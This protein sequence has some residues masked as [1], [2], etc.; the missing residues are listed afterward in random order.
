[1]R[2]LALGLIL[3]TLSVSA[4]CYFSESEPQAPV[5]EPTKPIDETATLVEGQEVGER[6]K[7][8][9]MAAKD[10]LFTSLSGRL[11]QAMSSGGPEGAIEICSKE[12]RSLASTVGEQENVRIGRT[13]VRLRNEQNVAPLW[14]QGLIEAKTDTPFFGVLSDERKVALL[15]IK[16]QSHCLACHGPKEQLAPAVSEQLAQLYPNDQATGFHDGE[17]RGWFWIETLR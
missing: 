13:G 4:G 7:A 5:A 3:T 11:M 16:L 15:P 9:L 17:L 6:D 12:A 2:R 10:A 1:M 8:R 14:A